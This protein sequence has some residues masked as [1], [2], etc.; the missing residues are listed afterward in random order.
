MPPPF[1]HLVIVLRHVFSAGAILT[2][3]VLSP[4][5]CIKAKAEFGD[6]VQL[7]AP[8][9]WP[10][11]LPSLSEVWLN[12]ASDGYVAVEYRP[13]SAATPGAFKQVQ[14]YFDVRGWKRC[15]TNM[16]EVVLLR[17]EQTKQPCLVGFGFEK[18]EVVEFTSDRARLIG[19]CTTGGCFL[20]GSLGDAS[21]LVLHLGDAGLV[22]HL[23]R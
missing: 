15:K 17:S 3:S 19:H 9:N 20:R 6:R 12:L 21:E 14:D 18:F 13:V 23:P 8:I 2:L 10:E 4:T 7:A 16:D 22:W 1:E 11:A 5:G